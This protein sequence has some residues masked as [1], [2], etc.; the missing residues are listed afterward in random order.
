MSSLSWNCRGLRNI[1]S[2]SVG[3]ISSL[4]SSSNLDFIFLSE[5]KSQV[6]LLEP[7]FSRLG[8]KGCTGADSN[9]SKGGLFLCWSKNVAVSII[10]VSQNYVCCSTSDVTGN[11]YFVAFVYGSPYVSDRSEV[12]DNLSSIMDNNKGKWMLIG[13]FNQVESNDQKLGGSNNLK[14]AT[15]FIE[16]KLMNQLMDLPYQGV[17]YTWTNNRVNKDAIYERID[18]A[19][20]NEEWREN[21]PDAEVWNLPILLSDHSPLILHVQ[22]KKKSSK[23]RP[24]RLDAWSLNHPEI[25]DIIKE[26]WK[27]AQE[28]SPSYVLQRKLQC[29]LRSIREWSLSFKKKNKI[30]WVDINT[31]LTEHQKGILDHHQA[32]TDQN[33]RNY[34]LNSLEVKTEYWKQRAKSR[35]DELGDKTSAF[36]Y[37]SVKGRSTRNEIKALKDLEGNWTSD[38]LKIKSSFLE[39]FKD[40]Y[41]CGLTEGSK[42][43]QDDPIFSP[44]A[45]LSQHHINLLNTPFSEKEIKDACFSASP[46]KSP[47]PDGIPP[48][49]FQ[50]NWSIVGQDVIRSVNS[51]LS[52]GFML[53]EQNRT[54]ITL[55]PKI[56]R[57]QEPKDF[58]PISLCNTSYKIIAKTLVS[59]LRLVMGDIVDKYQNAFVPGRQMSDNCFISHEI[60]NWV[61]KRK[62]GNSFAGI[63]KVDLSKAYDR[64]RWD[65]VE[66]MLRRMNFPETWIN[67]LM[68]CISTVSYSILVN[69]EPSDSFFPKVGLRQGDPLSSFIFI[70][71]MEVLSRNLSHMQFSR[72]LEGLKIAKS[73]PQISHLFFADDALFFFKANPKNCW[74]IKSILT[75]F[76][77]KSGEMINFEKSHVIFSPNT[78]QKFRRLM[79]RPLGVK[80]KNEIGSYLGCPME[81]DGRSTSVFNSIVSK[82]ADKISSWKFINLSQTGKLILINTILI[83]LASNI[84]SIYMLPKRITKKI[85]SMLLKFWWSSSMD[86]KPIYWKKRELIEKHKSQGGLSFRNI[87][88][89][90]KAMLF[91]QAWRIH[92]NKESLVHQIFV[93]KYKKDPIQMA[94]DGETPK[95]CSFAF[96]SLFGASKA[97]KDGMFKKLGNGKSIR[98]ESDRWHPGKI[99]KPKPIE[100]QD[101][102][103]QLLWV[104]DLI[105]QSKNWKPS[106]IW[107]LYSLEDAKEILATHIPREEIE[108][109]IG[110]SQTKNRRY[111]VKS[112]YWF[113]NGD[114]QVQP[115][116]TVFW[117]QFWKADIFPKWKHFLWKILNNA[118]PT[119]D[120]LLKRRIPGIKQMCCLCNSHNETPVHLFR[121]CVMTQRIWS[122]SLGIVASNGNHLTVQEWIKNFLNLFKKRKREDS[123]RMEIDFISTLWGIWVHRNEIIFK[124]A[125]P[126]PGR[127]MEVITDHSRRSYCIREKRERM[128]DLQHLGFEGDASKNLEWLM[129]ERNTANVQTIVVDGAWK[130]NHKSNHWQAAIAWKNVTKDSQEEASTRIFANSAEQTE[131]YAILK[132]VTDMEWRCSGLIIKSDNS[133]IIKALKSDTV[134]NKNLENIVR[135]IKRL[136]RATNHV[137]G[138]KPW[139][140]DVMEAIDCLIGLPN[141]P[142]VVATHK[143]PI[144]IFEHF[145]L[146]NVLF[147][148]KDSMREL[149]GMKL[150]PDELYYFYKNAPVMSVSLHKVA[151]NS[152]L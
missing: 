52:S 69:G 75:S 119:A 86:K 91:N 39:S 146:T 37:K 42:I 17:N 97:L 28:G 59:R 125:S 120:N 31:S 19:F 103:N 92:K 68:Q 99:M 76:C 43:D 51:F 11:E 127:I 20:C 88:N 102:L 109:E 111:S 141:G 123:L 117:N 16:W 107:K 25:L 128:Q 9:G 34:I 132:G 74:A 104:S 72:E 50:K 66:A 100:N 113:L 134:I 71:C 36:F 84:I 62:N 118:L 61:R 115:S 24:Y 64:I 41:R 149:I 105:D 23:K 67:W 94:M 144:R 38:Q 98:M 114:R 80:D 150:R 106:I 147:A 44:I 152:K 3:F 89:V 81:V 124:G 93:A 108:D 129:G 83:S 13:D 7:I 46:L 8:F 65:F 148:P 135:D 15:N 87:S 110:W 18:K 145:T 63:L 10:V 32:E 95:N 40:I 142:L 30:D 2:Q 96:R 12:W 151:S 14:G 79:R 140:F 57:P 35:W 58:R 77:E 22:E 33:S 112:G 47:G 55:I 26:D 130:K 121:D 137:T 122:T 143:G 4:A 126:S 27:R 49:F 6:S 70:L 45:S 90:N 138:E 116:N 29:S 60:I 53:R 1:S 101:P 56:D 85:T 82:V 136:A 5:T 139:L 78:P 48:V 73:A 21:F 133:E 54:F 131:A